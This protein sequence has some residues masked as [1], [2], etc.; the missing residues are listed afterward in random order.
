MNPLRWLLPLL[1]VLALAFPATSSAAGGA[2]GTSSV[3][4]TTDYLDTTNAQAWRYTASSGGAVDRLNLRLSAASP[5]TSF[6]LGLYANSSN[7]PG[8][9]LASCAVTAPKSDA[10][11]SC[12]IPSTTVASGTSYWLAAK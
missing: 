12:S 9:K 1:F 11:N 6:D 2:V 8:N 7:R 3:A 4:T 5:A 10:W